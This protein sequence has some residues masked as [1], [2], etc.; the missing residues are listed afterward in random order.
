MIKIV[1]ARQM[2]EMD[3]YTI[4]HLGVPGVVLM[5][6]AARGT[7]LIIENE[8]KD[9]EQPLVYVFCGKGNNGG[10]GFVISRYLWDS[11]ADVQVFVVGVEKDIKGDAKINYQII[12]NL[13]IPIIFINDQK[14]L[15]KTEKRN[16]DLI[17]DALL[18]TGI[19]G[20]VY[21]FMAEVINT[22][23][24]LKGIVVSVDVPSGLNSDLPVV[25]GGTVKADITV[26]MALPKYCHVFY[27]AR[28]HVG[29]LYVTEIGIP[30]TVRNSDDVTVQL[31]EDS[32]IRLPQR[33]PEMHK[34]KAGKVGVLAGSMG[35]TGA[36]ILT[37]QAAMQIGAG[38][39]Y[40]GIPEKLNQ[41]CESSLREVIT[42]PYPEDFLSAESRV[43][44]EVLDW[45]DVLAIG[46]GL[47][48]GQKTQQAIIDILKDFRKPLIVDADAL[49]ALAEHPKI[50]NKAHPNWILTPHHGEFL[51]LLSGITKKEFEKNFITLA[52]KY[53]V[54]HQLILLLKGAPS[55]VACPDGRI[56][57]NS[58]GNPGLASG[59]TGD[60]LTGF[61]AGLAAQG[62]D[63]SEAAYTAN[64][65][66]GYIADQLLQE[67]ASHSI[68]A[69]DLLDKTGLVMKD[70]Q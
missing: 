44:A 31:L 67:K 23:N 10:D 6:N 46:P 60:V 24:Q 53:A 40:L 26:S 38:L 28:R 42:K 12:K 45:C 3:N 4:K 48:R 11:G 2:R 9:F 47:G 18:G 20:S 49:F 51:R 69:G 34:Y 22:I 15:K 14:D 57:V 21:G 16:P 63:N 8:L 39:V 33:T 65:L 1:T 27:P 37:S 64:F 62:M 17:V 25:E 54:D 41:I 19:T 70:F 68:L 35:Y 29:E 58:T 52:Q 66:H 61:V 13:N 5:E 56:Y 43:V 55:I 59:G 30:H 36:A 7:F 32:D 50:L